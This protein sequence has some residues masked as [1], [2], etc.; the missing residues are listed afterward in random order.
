MRRLSHSGTALGSDRLSALV[1]ARRRYE[2]VRTHPYEVNMYIYNTQCKGAPLAPVKVLPHKPELRANF[3]VILGQVVVC[4]VVRA[5]S[6][7]TAAAATMALR[8]AAATAEAAVEHGTELKRVLDVD[9][10]NN[11]A[12][13]VDADA[14]A[15]PDAGTNTRVA[16]T[17]ANTSVVHRVCEGSLGRTSNGYLWRAVED[18]SPSWERHRSWCHS[19]SW[20]RCRCWWH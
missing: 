7:L 1:P 9:F 5:S 3:Q 19:R 20:S 14:D 6:E 10:A 15:N 16:D 11:V 13:H 8:D 17:D 18:R 12:V 4:Q 2:E